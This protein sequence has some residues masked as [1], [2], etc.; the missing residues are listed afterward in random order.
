M[1]LHIN[2][3]TVS[4]EDDVWSAEIHT[5]D[6]EE[7]AISDAMMQM[8]NSD[9]F[10]DVGA[11]TGIWSIF[12][13]IATEAPCYA[14]EPYPPAI[15]RMRENIKLNNAEVSVTE[16][17]M[18]DESGV[19]TLN[20]DTPYDTV[21]RIDRPGDIVVEVVHPNDAVDMNGVQKP[22]VVKLDVEGLEERLVEAFI[23]HS[24]LE[25]RL[26]YCEVHIPEDDRT[27]PDRIHKK[28]G[29]GGYN[30]ELVWWRESGVG[31]H[32]EMIKGE[33]K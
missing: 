19:D 33:L 20:T 5:S 28:L 32:V 25:P 4:L 9:V 30:T 27:R 29:Q 13:N 8:N 12:I 2:G 16:V 11:Y 22:T 6:T 31:H 10:W 14:F 23:R 1:N 7:E 17:A 3:H 26:I 24:P 18:S 21:N 15:E